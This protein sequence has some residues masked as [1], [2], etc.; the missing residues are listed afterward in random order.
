MPPDATPPTPHPQTEPTASEKG[1]DVVLGERP[2]HYIRLPRQVRRR[3]RVFL[4]ASILIV[5]MVLGLAHTWFTNQDDSSEA[6]EVTIAP[7]DNVAS[8]TT[9]IDEVAGTSEREVVERVKKIYHDMLS[10][11]RP[12][13][14]TYLSE[15]FRSVVLAAQK[16][17][18]AGGGDILDHNLWTQ[19]CGTGCTI[20]LK[21][22]A[23]ESHDRATAE[24]RI[25]GR[26]SHYFNN[27]NVTLLLLLEHGQ[28]MVD[29]ILTNHGS[30]KAA[31]KTTTDEAVATL[32]QQQRLQKGD[33]PVED[34]PMHEITLNGT[35]RGEH[36]QTLHMH[37][38]ITGFTVTGEQT[39]EDGERTTWEG[40]IDR[41][42]RMVLR[43]LKN[44]HT[45]NNLMDGV[46]KNGAYMGKYKS[47]SHDEMDFKAYME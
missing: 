30:E 9:T 26:W 47:N 17:E 1:H 20:Q 46:L 5:I 31:I 18:K 28:W 36:S 41:N 29:D 32:R 4:A 15:D 12:F 2:N 16:V 45:T 13:N 14:Q 38:L 33:L 35:L 44:G 3:R 6:E 7:M 27:V 8:K 11:T 34:T 40:E 25:S 10:D 21:D 43:E 39:T 42:G 22:A 24:V 37:L 19:G 23:V